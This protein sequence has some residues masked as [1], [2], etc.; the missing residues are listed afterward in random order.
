[1]TENLAR[2]I[3]TVDVGAGHHGVVLADLRGAPTWEPPMPYWAGWVP[4]A[5]LLR[6]LGGRVWLDE[7]MCLEDLD[8]LV[9][10]EY[11]IYGGAR[12]AQSGEAAIRQGGELFGAWDTKTGRPCY[13]TSAGAVRAILIKS[14]DQEHVHPAETYK[15][16]ALKRMVMARYPQTGGGATPA[17]GV[18][19]DQG[20][21]WCMKPKI[22]PKNDHH[23]DAL[24]AA[25][26]AWLEGE[27]R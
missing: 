18:Q 25:V 9:L 19:K 10:E 27:F 1:M 11:R 20:P 8:H 2:T 16:S 7:S 17:V 5:D 13:R 6:F 24:R 14:E 23:W 12:V 15:A 26:A 3:L 22:A 21:L 4:H